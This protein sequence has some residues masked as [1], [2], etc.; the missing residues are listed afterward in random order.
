[1]KK[2]A[3]FLLLFSLIFTMIGCHAQVPEETSGKPSGEQSNTGTEHMMNV[4]DN[5]VSIPN[6]EFV[7]DND[8]TFVE[9]L[10]KVTAETVLSFLDIYQD[11][12][13]QV[14]YEIDGIQFGR[15]IS[16]SDSAED[17][18]N[19]CTRHFTSTR[20]PD[21]IHTVVECEV[22]YESDL[23]YGVYVAWEVDTFI[24]EEN[25]ISFK[26]SVADI[27]AYNVVYNDEESFRICT[28]DEEQIREILLYLFYD[29]CRPDVLLHYELSSDENAYY[30]TMYSHY[31]SYGDW[32]MLDTYYF[33]EQPI[34]IDKADGSVDFQE[35]I[36]L[37]TLER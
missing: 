6:L 10:S 3:L 12:T 9:N 32:D 19:V 20:N 27:T 30:L 2:F 25:V 5:T 21:S 35:Y 11:N 29:K 26:K 17:A 24:Y 4:P 28:D 16:S 8:L 37:S 23:F 36:V 13:Y 18:V 14:L 31:I 22:I 34:I 1:M 33:V 15:V 7:P